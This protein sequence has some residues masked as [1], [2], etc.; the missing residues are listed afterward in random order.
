MAPRGPGGGTKAAGDPRPGAG[1][2]HLAWVPLPVSFRW[3]VLVDPP[4][5]GATNMARDHALAL[6]VGEGEGVLRIYRWSSPT[7]SFGRNEPA[8]GLYRVDEGERRGFGFVRR[9]TGGR[10]VLH[11]LELTY[12][13]VAPLAALGGPRAAYLRI[14]EGVVQ[15]IRALGVEV[16]LARNLGRAPSPG[17]GPCFQQPAEGEVVVGGRKLVGSAQVRLGRNLLQHGSLLL[18][19]D[20]SPLE[21]LRVVPAPSGSASTSLLHLMGV[22][23]SWDR[24]VAQL[25][26]GLTRTLGGTWSRGGYRQG[27]LATAEEL[28]AKYSDPSW[29]WR[30]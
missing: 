2:G 19:G 21:D 15:G 18:D 14:N 16:E 27:E 22:L 1:M 26:E 7:V 3:R 6:H 29:T 28:E 8:K 25:E 10:A 5:A 17:A 9:P 13:V 30:L 20:Q 4:L 12:A 24:L 11:H 23:P